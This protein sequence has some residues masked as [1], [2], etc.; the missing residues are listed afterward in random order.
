MRVGNISTRIAAIGRVDRRHVEHEDQEKRHHHEVV[1]ARWV[2]LGRVLRRVERRLRLGL[3]VSAGGGGARCRSRGRRG[4]GRSVADVDRGG[5][6]RGGGVGLYDGV[7][8]PR[9]SPTV[10]AGA[11]TFEYGMPRETS[12]VLAMSHEVVNLEVPTG[13]NWNERSAGRRSRRPAKWRWPPEG[14]V[15]V[16]GDALEEREVGQACNN[17]PAMMIGLRP[18]RW[19]SV[20]S[21]HSLSALTM[22]PS[23]SAT[24]S[25]GRI[26]SMRRSTPR[27]AKC[28]TRGAV[29]SW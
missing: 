13:L 3:E 18:M 1:G 17:S 2:G 7:A 24:S 23:D 29:C 16:V 21:G 26:A 19:L 20:L 11:S 15:G 8:R 5:G 14:R 22:P 4:R 6:R 25:M 27:R 10:P 9:S 28:S 12:A